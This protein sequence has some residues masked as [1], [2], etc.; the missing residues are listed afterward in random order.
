MAAVRDSLAPALWPLR[1]KAV[2]ED[3]LRAAVS[4]LVRNVGQI[5]SDALSWTREVVDDRPPAAGEAL[6][7]RLQADH[8]SAST[9]RARSRMLTVTK[10]PSV[11]WYIDAL[12]L[13]LPESSAAARLARDR[14]LQDERYSP[15]WGSSVHLRYLQCTL[16]H[17]TLSQ[18]G[19]SPFSLHKKRRHYKIQEPKGVQTTTTRP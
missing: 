6:P 5:V 14:L 9:T 7:P 13:D 15:W 4:P 19:I 18:S 11:R 16:R 10:L 12:P 3:S 17:A 1:N 2:P 8:T